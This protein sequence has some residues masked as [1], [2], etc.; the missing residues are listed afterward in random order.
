[1]KI[2]VIIAAEFDII[3]DAFDVKNNLSKEG[4]YRIFK[5]TGDVEEVVF[6]ESGPGEI[7]AAAGIQYLITRFKP[8]VILN[9][10]VCGGLDAE[11]KKG[12]L[13]IVKDCVHTDYNVSTVADVRQG[14]YIGLSSEKIRFEENLI[15]L[16]KEYF[17]NKRE[18]H[19]VSLASQDRIIHGD[20]ERI[21]L[22]EKWNCQICDMEL[23][24]YAL[25]AI[26]NRVPLLGV[27]FVSDS[28]GDMLEFDDNGLSE[29]VEIINEIKGLLGYLQNLYKC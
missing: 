22:G 23:S 9:L 27:K 24:G 4:C 13:C 3:I 17:H 26:K 2:A 7:Q 8:D 16:C 25:V 12:D 18:F 5:W 28:V 19:C 20:N 11:I 14:Q 10:G 6:F 1:M 15:Q 21:A 29:F